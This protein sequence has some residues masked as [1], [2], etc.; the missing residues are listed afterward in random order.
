MQQDQYGT[1]RSL[2]AICKSDISIIVHGT[3]LAHG[4]NLALTGFANL[5]SGSSLY[6]KFS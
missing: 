1:D 2:Q 6:F 4:P 3:T 5:K